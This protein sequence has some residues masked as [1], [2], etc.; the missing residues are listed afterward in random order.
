MSPYHFTDVNEYDLLALS[1]ECSRLHV[2]QTLKTVLISF[3]ALH[4][5]FTDVFSHS[6]ARSLQNSETFQGRLSLCF[7]DFTAAY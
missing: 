3:P 6:F 7:V 5:H 2:Y 4:R 1:E